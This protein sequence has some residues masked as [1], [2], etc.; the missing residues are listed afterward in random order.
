MSEDRPYIEENTR[1]RER[2]RA[3][4]ERVWTTMSSALR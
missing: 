3:L 4:V 2:L 1:E